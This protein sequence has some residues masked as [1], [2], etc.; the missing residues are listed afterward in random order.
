MVVVAYAA[1]TTGHWWGD[2]W[3][4]YLRQAEGLL[5]RAGGVDSVID[6]NRFTVEFS[7][8]TEFSPPL[9][10]WGFP[11]LLAP[12]VAVLGDDLDRLMAVEVLSF[13]A[14]LVMWFRLAR[15]RTGTVIA[16]VSAGIFAMSPQ[17]LRWTELIQSE[18]PYMA[19]AATALVLLDRESTRRSWITPGTS[20][21]PLV[22][23]GVAAAAVFTVRREGLA[24]VPAIAI[25]QLAALGAWWWAARPGRPERV[26]WWPL[27]GRLAVPHLCW[28]AVVVFLQLVLPS[29]L[30]PSYSG[31]GVG[32]LFEFASD[33][34]GHVAESLGLKDVPTETPTVL[35]NAVAGWIAVAAFVVLTLAGLVWAVWRRPTTDL[36][37]V[38]FG[39]VVLVI[40]GSFRFPG[41][42]Y[43][44]MVAPIALIFAGTALRRLGERVARPRVAQLAA[45]LLL[46]ALLIGNVVRATDQIESARLFESRDAVE[47]GPTAQPAVDMF[48]AVDRITEPDAVVG[49]FK[50][51]AMSQRIDRRSLQVGD[52]R[53]VADVTDLLDYVVLER[54]DRQLAIVQRDPERYLQRWTNARFTLFQVLP[55]T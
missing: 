16:L 14:F 31:T 26:A 38:A 7:T 35:G 1:R 13:A 19:V 44:A 52:R 3:A 47:W 2:D 37:I 4:L 49:F 53:A 32:N 12:F 54:G 6:D 22:W 43:V 21:W 40:G 17:Y 48:D 10:P 8:G 15:P 27:L 42:R 9:Y 11:L 45:G 30:V 36:P 55:R 50:A 29:T 24:M 51:R 28:L 41:T 34:L 5:G 23:T 33:H 20:W 25:G 18:L 46:S 39:L